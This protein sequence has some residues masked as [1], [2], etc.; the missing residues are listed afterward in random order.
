MGNVCSSGICWLLCDWQQCSSEVQVWFLT[1]VPPVQCQYFGFCEENLDAL[2][3]HHGGG[4]V[5]AFPAP[6]RAFRRHGFGSS[7]EAWAMTHLLFW[8]QY[9]DADWKYSD[10]WLPLELREVWLWECHQ[11]LLKGSIK[12]LEKPWGTF[13]CSASTHRTVEG[14]N[15]E[16]SGSSRLIGHPS[17]QDS[18]PLGS[19]WCIFLQIPVYSGLSHQRLLAL[20]SVQDEVCDI[21]AGGLLFWNTGAKIDTEPGEAALL[22]HPGFKGVD[23]VTTPQGRPFPASVLFASCQGRGWLSCSQQ[24]PR[25]FLHCPLHPGAHGTWSCAWLPSC[26]CAVLP[27]QTEGRSCMSVKLLRHV[28]TFCWVT[29]SNLGNFDQR[30]MTGAWR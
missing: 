30:K 12:A 29:A 19:S 17:H 3:P 15:W 28:R 16:E 2:H 9:L 22:Q 8:G 27:P 14:E 24:K 1:L 18:W 7:A 26:R 25:R 20:A 21:P 13:C 10:L 11:L 4:N 23:C 5:R 6:A